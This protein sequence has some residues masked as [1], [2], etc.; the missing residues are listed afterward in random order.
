[1]PYK[2]RRNAVEVRHLELLDAV[3]ARRRWSDAQVAKAIGVQTDRIPRW[4]SHGVPNCYVSALRA[5]RDDESQLTQSPPD[6]AAQPETDNG[7]L[8]SG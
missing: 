7:S 1:V 4:R 5:L 6:I 8:Q 3:V 2:G